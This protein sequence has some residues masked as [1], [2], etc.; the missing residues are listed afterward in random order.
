MSPT[1][2]LIESMAT[3]HGVPVLDCLEFYLERAA[4]REFDGNQSRPDAESGA[5][6]DVKIWIALWN[7]PGV[8]K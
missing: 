4:I 8:R 6:E 3:T 7:T 2:A 5:V 1:S